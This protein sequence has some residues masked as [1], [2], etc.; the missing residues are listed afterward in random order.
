MTEVM[1][2]MVNMVGVV[3]MTKFIATLVLMM[4]TV[5]MVD[6]AAACADMGDGDDDDD[7]D[8]ATHDS[9]VDVA[10]YDDSDDCG[11]DD[12]YGWR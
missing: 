1:T 9:G 7:G 2:S 5:R 10:E 6:I 8:A 12:G 11:D 3:T 4:T